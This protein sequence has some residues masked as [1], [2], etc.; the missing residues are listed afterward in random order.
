[1]RL[2]SLLLL[3]IASFSLSADW[4]TGLI[5]YEKQEYSKAKAEFSQLL[6]L[7]NGKAAFNLGVMAYYGEGQPADLVAALAYFMLASHLQHPEADDILTR[8]Q[9]EATTE[10]RRQAQL[11]AQQAEQALV[12]KTDFRPYRFSHDHPPA[13]QNKSMPDIP[14]DVHR[15]HPFGYIVLRYLVDGNGRVQVV[16][17]VDAFPSGVFDPY[18]FR[19]MRR[20]QYEATGKQHLMTTQINF[21]VRGAM[22]GR[23]ATWLLSHQNLWNNA[24][25]GAPRQQ[26]IL[27]SVLNLVNIVADGNLMINPDLP[28]DNNVPDLTEL[29]RKQQLRFTLSSF[30]G[31]VEVQTDDKGEIIRVLSSQLLQRPTAEELVGQR[32]RGA[33]AGLYSLSRAS[34]R[35]SAII[36]PYVAMS[37]AMSPLYWWNQAAINGDRL[38]QRILGAQRE[39]WQFYL[40][41]Q[42]DPQA[43]AWHGARLIL[44]GETSEGQALLQQ[45][46]EAGYRQ[47][48]ELLQALLPEKV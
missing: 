7:G 23:Q 9:Q 36:Q 18:T 45:A 40:L 42:G 26:E 37:E 15:K 25:A 32:I 33:S 39:D 8:L 17:T 20:W 3:S 13:V 19:A 38:A 12:I 6:P 1:M 4:L 47:A 28:F 5:A 24:L 2:C 10:Q 29:F 27:G 21:W 31:S 22:T 35:D 30:V 34:R 11:L 16:D 46:V 14:D 48:T 43:M 44:D 41:Q